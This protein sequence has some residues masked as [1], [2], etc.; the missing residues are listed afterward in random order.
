MVR[1]RHGWEE[2]REARKE[3]RENGEEA[4]KENLR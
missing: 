2:E 4:G 3:E 1:E